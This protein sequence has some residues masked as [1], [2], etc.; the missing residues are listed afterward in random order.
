[1]AGSEVQNIVE[2]ILEAH[3][4]ALRWRKLELSGNAVS[5]YAG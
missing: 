4:G 2:K 5:F 3:G 1:M